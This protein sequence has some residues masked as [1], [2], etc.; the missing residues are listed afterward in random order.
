[1]SELIYSKALKAGTQ[2]ASDRKKDG[3][4]AH[5]PVLD[6]LISENEI[7]S[8]V[9]LGIQEIPMSLIAGTY[10][11]GRHETFAPNFMPLLELNTAFS[12]KW[13]CPG[14]KQTGQRFKVF[15]SKIH[16]SGCYPS[17]SKTD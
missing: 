12:A 13:I 7:V 3:L 1:M 10:T 5:L 6:K 11:A 15:R 4:S 14:G 17:D 9:S 16:C 8:E 2:C